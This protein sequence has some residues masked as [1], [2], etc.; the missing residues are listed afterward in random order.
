MIVFTVHFVGLYP[1]V[2]DPFSS[3]VQQLP[4][5]N[6]E[7]EVWTGVYHVLKEWLLIA[8]IVRSFFPIIVKGDEKRNFSVL[9]IRPQMC[10]NTLYWKIV[11]L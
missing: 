3:K 8:V 1:P 5:I 9:Y 4:H 7:N 2:S 11:Q 10:M 6:T